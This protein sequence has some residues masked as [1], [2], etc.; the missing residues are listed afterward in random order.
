VEHV[1]V[2]SSE[3]VQSWIRAATRRGILV[4]AQSGWTKLQNYLDH[5]LPAA[6][7]RD[8]ISAGVARRCG[9][10]SRPP[11]PRSTQ[12]TRLAR[13]Q[14]RSPQQVPLAPVAGA[15]G[16][17]G[18]HA[19]IV[20]YRNRSARQARAELVVVQRI[21]QPGVRGFSIWDHPTESAG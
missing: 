20:H 10:T 17:C 8:L 21:Y 6:T 9:P 14:P 2:V 18:G 15:H 13:R 12:S 3:R 4:V 1:G 16:C 19:L 11:G 5:R 7:I